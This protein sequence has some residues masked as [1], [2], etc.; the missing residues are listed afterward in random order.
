VVTGCW[1]CG[2]ECM[3]CENEEPCCSF[4]GG[5]PGHW[6]AECKF[7]ACEWCCGCSECRANSRGGWSP[8]GTQRNHDG[9]RERQER[10]SD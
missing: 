7:A 8:K 9:I 3:F 2:Q 4:P 10:T 5:T 1:C 6:C